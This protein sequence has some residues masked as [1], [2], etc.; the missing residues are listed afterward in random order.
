[1]QTIRMFRVI[2]AKIIKI[3]TCVENPS[4]VSSLYVANIPYVKQVSGASLKE[5]QIASRIL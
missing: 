2:T 4:E 3:T 1:M 5:T